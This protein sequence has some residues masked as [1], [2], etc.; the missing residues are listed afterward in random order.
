MTTQRIPPPVWLAIALALVVVLHRYFP[1]ASLIPA[2]WNYAGIAIAGLGVVL[3]VWSVVL[4]RR[5]STTIIPFQE[6]TA[7]I[8]WGPYRLTRNPIYLSMALLLLGAAV[9]AGSLSP[10]I[11]IPVF[12]IIIQKLFIS[13]EEAM[14]AEKFPAEFPAYRRKVR[15][16]L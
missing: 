16:W 15:R 4:Y 10:F 3:A 11:V 2:P 1:I 13:P 14:L 8:T 7:L 12:V 9:F 5:A 6:S